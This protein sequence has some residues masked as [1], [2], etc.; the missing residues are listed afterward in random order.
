M[1]WQN[2]SMK[3]KTKAKTSIM[4]TKLKK[5]EVQ[6]SEEESSREKLTGEDLV[7]SFKGFS[8]WLHGLT[9]FRGR[10]SRRRKLD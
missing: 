1:G 7:E 10:S 3:K 4:K 9:S 5:K 6:Q 2:Q 8:L